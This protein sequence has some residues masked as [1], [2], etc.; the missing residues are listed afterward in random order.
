MTYASGAAVLSPNKNVK[1]VRLMRKSFFRLYVD[2][3]FVLLA[4]K[5]AGMTKI[6][7]ILEK[8]APKLAQCANFFVTLQSTN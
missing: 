1:T 4:D 6:L 3:Y 8:F 5:L 2:Y 7:A